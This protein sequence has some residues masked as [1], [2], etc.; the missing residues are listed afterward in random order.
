VPKDE[1]KKVSEDQ[2]RS[3]ARKTGAKQHAGSGSGSRRLDMHTE[4]SLI[5]CKTV[6]RGNKQITLK[7]DDLRLLSY[8]AAIQD[9]TPILHVRLDNKDWVLLPEADYLDLCDS[10]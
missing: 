4:D 8:H 3:I 2:E 7:V 6:L 9:R 1:R 10:Q 5:E